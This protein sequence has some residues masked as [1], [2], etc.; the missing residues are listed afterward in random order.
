MREALKRFAKMSDPPSEFQRQGV[1]YAETA[2]V[3]DLHAGI[4]RG[5][6]GGEVAIKPFSLQVLV[7]LGLAFFLAGF[8][9]ARQGAEFTA[10][11][12]DRSNAQ[13][14][15]SISPEVQTSAAS[16]STAPGT[17][18]DA[19][20]PLV[21]HVS[22]KNMKFSPATIEIK[23]GETVEWKNEDITPHTATSPTFDSKS[24]DPDQVWRHAFPDAGNF[25]YSC[26]FHPEMKATIIVK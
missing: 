9:S 11:S 26:T 16:A 6:S 20:A 12:L 10:A 25:Q 14:S 4:R 23:K 15:Q 7:V 1:D 21:A 22:M 8:F 19:N 3:Q 18:A 17:V 2:D 5:K 13:P 24:I